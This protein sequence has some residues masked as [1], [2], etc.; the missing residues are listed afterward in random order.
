MEQNMIFFQG[1]N[2]KETFTYWSNGKWHHKWPRS[3]ACGAGKELY[4][5]IL[6]IDTLHQGK[7]LIIT[8]GNYPEN[9][10]RTRVFK[11]SCQINKEE[12]GWRFEIGQFDIDSY[13]LLLGLDFFIKID[14]MVDVE[15][16]LIQIRQGPGNNVQVLP[17][18][19]N[20]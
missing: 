12:M 1:Q 14:A 13:D 2:S 15:K 8:Y 18:N 4:N 19:V 3:N 11:E 6:N 16:G 17:L 5:E 10:K 9:T 20:D 7:Y